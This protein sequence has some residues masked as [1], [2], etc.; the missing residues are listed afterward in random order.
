M[1][2]NG[3]ESQGEAGFGRSSI[4]GQ[5]SGVY[6]QEAAFKKG[7]HGLRLQ[8]YVL[9][10]Y[11]DV[12]TSPNAGVEKGFLMCLTALDHKRVRLEPFDT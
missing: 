8:I 10:K 12:L 4:S 9:L 7:L 6:K 3:L 5:D 11:S 1:A 2:R